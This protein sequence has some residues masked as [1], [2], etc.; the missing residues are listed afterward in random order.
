MLFLPLTSEV[1]FLLT[2]VLALYH[3]SK[4]GTPNCKLIDYHVMYMHIYRQGIIGSWI[5]DT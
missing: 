4:V 1:Q 5:I 3:V 2:S